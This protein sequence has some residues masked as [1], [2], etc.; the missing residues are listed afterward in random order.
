MI[1][2]SDCGVI[3]VVP[4]PYGKGTAEIVSKLFH[5]KHLLQTAF[6]LD[7]CRITFDGDSYFNGIHQE[8]DYAWIRKLNDCL[9]L[10]PFISVHPVGIGDML[11]LIKRIHSRW[12]ARMFAMR[13]GAERLFFSTRRINEADFLSP[14]V[15][16]QARASNCMILFLSNYSCL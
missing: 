11:H 2:F 14:V 3:H 12:V 8:F 6:H 4:A 7:G 9:R 16:R 10:F 13:C 5:L 15:F 1:I